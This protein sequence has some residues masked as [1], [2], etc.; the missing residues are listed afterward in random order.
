[1]YVTVTQYF[2]I[3]LQEEIG[4]LLLNLKFSHAIVI[5]FSGDKRSPQS[6]SPDCYYA[7]VSFT[8][9]TG[10]PLGTNRLSDNV[11]LKVWSF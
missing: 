4:H 1:M 10:L 6:L 3:L 5:N 7:C 9:S 8:T 11:H 2:L